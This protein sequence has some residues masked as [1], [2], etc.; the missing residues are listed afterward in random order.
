MPDLIPKAPVSDESLM[1]HIV[2]LH[3]VPWETYEAVLAA[4]GDKSAPRINY[5]EGELEI[6]SPSIF[7]EKIGRMIDALLRVWADVMDA[8][9]NS[10]GSWTIKMRRHKR[11]AEADNCY[12]LGRDEDDRPARPD[13]AIEVEWTPGG[14]EKLEVWRVLGVPEIWFWRRGSFEVFV[15]RDAEYHAVKRS[16]LL[17]ELDVRLLAKFVRRKDQIQAL[18]EYRAALRRRRH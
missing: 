12:L 10:F 2:V 9:L 5:L 13:L 6:M 8:S 16:V 1:D 7:H 11:G 18:R 4:R 3:D 15:L 17:P 14:V